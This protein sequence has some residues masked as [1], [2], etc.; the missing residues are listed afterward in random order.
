MLLT[1]SVTSQQLKILN[2]GHK[3]GGEFTPNAEV[4]GKYSGS[5]LGGK[6]VGASS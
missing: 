5:F 3:T 1:E 2:E 4:W 6:A